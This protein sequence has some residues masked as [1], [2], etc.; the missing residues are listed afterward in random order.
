MT[1]LTRGRARTLAFVSLLSVSAIAVAVGGAASAST[2]SR[3]LIQIHEQ[4][5]AGSQAG[6][7]GSIRGKGHH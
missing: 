5:K 3:S 1:S 2:A 4:G 7:T 6:V